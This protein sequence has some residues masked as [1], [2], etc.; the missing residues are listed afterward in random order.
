M[1]IELKVKLYQH[2]KNE[3]VL[4]RQKIC[5]HYGNEI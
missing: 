4:C 5:G 3:I 1:K 2:K